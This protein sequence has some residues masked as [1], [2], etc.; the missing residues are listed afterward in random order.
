MYQERDT[1]IS[2]R[3]TFMNGRNVW[4]KNMWY[5]SGLIILSV[6]SL[7]LMNMMDL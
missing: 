4:V 3:L 1:D 5:Y 7:I 6:I 2:F